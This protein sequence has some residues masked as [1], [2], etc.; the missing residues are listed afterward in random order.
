M[1][2]FSRLAY[3]GTK[4]FV[5]A[6]ARNNPLTAQFTRGGGAMRGGSTGGDDVLAELRGEL[7]YSAGYAAGM[8]RRRKIERKGLELQEAVM[9][10]EDMRAAA[11]LILKFER[12]W[13]TPTDV[14]DPTLR[15]WVEAMR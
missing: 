7:A 12:R 6:S 1:V 5:R 10:A 4:A 3:K 15:A 8:R 9:A 13:K 14:Q 11:V 2:N